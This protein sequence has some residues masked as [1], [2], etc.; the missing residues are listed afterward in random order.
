[1][2]EYEGLFHIGVIVADMQK[3]LDDIARR[4]GA[5]FPD[6]RDAQVSIRH[7][8]EGFDA[9]AMVNIP[10]ADTFAIRAAVAYTDNEGWVDAPLRLTGAE[11]DVNTVERLSLSSMTFPHELAAVMLVEQLYRASELQRGSGY[12]KA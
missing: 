1:M 5:S 10:L 9:N 8:G 6:P 7:G 12:H 3:G 2:I 4:F 11:D